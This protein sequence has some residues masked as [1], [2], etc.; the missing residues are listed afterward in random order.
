MTAKFNKDTK[1]GDVIRYM[2][3]QEEYPVTIDHAEKIKGI[4]SFE[5]SSAGYTGSY[6]FGFKFSLKLGD[7]L[8]LEQLE[9]DWDK[10]PE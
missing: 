2:I 10:D 7:D 4:Y 9:M 6:I 3:Q 8:H 1:V 5:G